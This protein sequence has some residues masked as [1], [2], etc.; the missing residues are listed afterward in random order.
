V[1]VAT[2]IAVVVMVLTVY[3]TIRIA[4]HLVAWEDSCDRS[5]GRTESPT[6][7]TDVSIMDYERY[8]A[9]YGAA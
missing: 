1:Y 3:L 2:G 6:V 7:S 9:A 8:G 5:N 4:E